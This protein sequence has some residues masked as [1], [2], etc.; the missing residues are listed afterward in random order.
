MTLEERDVLLKE[1]LKPQARPQSQPQPPQ[2]VGLDVLRAH[3]KGEISSL[4]ASFL[5]Y[6]LGAVPSQVRAVLG[7]KEPKD[8]A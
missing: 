4:E 7:I 5:L 8:G 1:F 3:R 6:W 2:A